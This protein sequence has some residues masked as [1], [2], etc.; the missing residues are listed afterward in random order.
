MS[1]FRLFASDK[2]THLTGDLIQNAIEN[3]SINMPTDWQ[4][5]GIQKCVIS[6]V[7]IQ[8]DQ[9]LDLELILWATSG[10][11]NTDHDLDRMITRISF[12]AATADQIAGANQYYY[13]NALV[14]NIEYRDDDKTSKVHFGIV[15]RDATTKNTAATGTVTLDTGAAGSVDSITVNGVEIMSGAEAFD[16]NLNTTA[17]NVA[18]NITANTSVPDYNASATGAVITIT[19]VTLGVSVNTFAVVS[20]ATTIT[21]TDTNMTGALGNLVVKFG[22]TAIR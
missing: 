2:D 17:T 21:T 11:S 15:N 6:E 16:T 9:D 22:A 19:A 20:T 7:N 14:Q 1:A 13:K 12:P 18:S 8:C 3:E 4:T 5:D 10:Y